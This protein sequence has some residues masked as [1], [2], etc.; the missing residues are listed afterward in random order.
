MLAQRVIVLSPDKAIGK[1][2]ALAVKVAGAAVEHLTSRSELG[3]GSLEAALVVMHLDGT[4]AGAGPE[5]LARLTGATQAIAILPRADLAAVVAIMRASERVAGILVAAD[6]VPA[7]LAALATRVLDGEVFGLAKVVP[8]GTQIHT[9]LVGSYDDKA[10]CIAQVSA[11]AEEMGVRR[12]YRESIDTCLDEMLMNALYDAPVDAHGQPLFPDVATR[13]QAVLAPEHR[14]VVQ[15]ACDGK[16]FAIA[17]RDAFGRL[18]RG[19]VLRYLHKCLYEEQQ[20]DKKAGGAGLGLYLMT[21]SSSTV[22]FNVQPRVATEALCTF[23][24]QAPKL[25]LETFGFFTER[26]AQPAAS[27]PTP[28]VAAP[29]AGSQALLLSV[30]VGAIMAT[31][32]LIAIVLSKR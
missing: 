25:E 10:Q 22:M 13:T 15:Y 28:V 18:E 11:F 14:A 2:L 31:L 26:S 1:Q 4:L 19:T 17:V 7:E 30:L 21:S 16:Q 27:V 9:A 5:L 24:L 6:L 29:A 20:I 32:A 23:D 8:W 3:T 12:K